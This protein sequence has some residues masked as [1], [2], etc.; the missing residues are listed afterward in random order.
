MAQTSLSVPRVTLTLNFP[1]TEL[2]RE[3]WAHSRTGRLVKPGFWEAR[4]ASSLMGTA[5]YEWRNTPFPDDVWQ[6]PNTGVLMMMPQVL[7]ADLFSNEA[8]LEYAIRRADFLWGDPDQVE[9]VENPATGGYLT[10]LK[11]PTGS[12]LTEILV[13]SALS[14]II[15]L[16]FGWIGRTETLISVNQGWSAIISPAGLTVDRAKAYLGFHWANN[17]YIEFST[18][19]EFTVAYNFGNMDAAEWR[20]IHRA[21]FKTGSVDHKLPFQVTVIPWGRSYISVLFSQVT[22]GATL[23]VPRDPKLG[24]RGAQGNAFLIDLSEHGIPT[25]WADGIAQHIKTPGA[26]LYVAANIDSNQY[27]FWISRVVYPESATFDTGPV[28]MDFAKSVVPTTEY[29]GFADYDNSR[30]GAPKLSLSMID[31]AGDPWTT[32]ETIG[33]IRVSMQSDPEQKYSPELWSYVAKVD[34]VTFTPDWTPVDVSDKWASIRLELTARSQASGLTVKLLGGDLAKYNKRGGP[35]RLEIDR[36]DGSGTVPVFDGYVMRREPTTEGAVVAGMIRGKMREE[37]DAQDMWHRLNSQTMARALPIEN[38]SVSEIIREAIQRTGQLPSEIEIDAEL[39][40]I[41]YS[42]VV[43]ADQSKAWS[44]DTYVGDVVR[45]VEKFVSAQFS[46]GF[47]VR[48]LGDRW[49]CY[50]AYAWDEAELWPKNIFLLDGGLM[51][52]WDEVMGT[53]FDGLGRSDVERWNPS[54]A[55]GDERFYLM[56]SEFEPDINLPAFNCLEVIAPAGDKDGDGALMAVIDPDPEVLLDSESLIFEGRLRKGQKGPPEITDASEDEI[57]RWARWFYD[58]EQR[59]GTVLGMQG[60]WQPEVMPDGFVMI[61]GRGPG[62]D[63]VS[64][65]C[66]RIE[67]INVDIES[68]RQQDWSWSGS[69]DLVYQGPTAHPYFPMVSDLVDSIA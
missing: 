23:G 22:L 4:S 48:W 46:D 35:I 19:G 24:A 62:G 34:P 6:E 14:D 51:A 33:A 44:S 20:E 16:G 47:R 67:S 27:V 26:P 9:E 53:A 2:L 12:S 13:A 54:G 43:T 10:V 29:R 21:S 56:T 18:A 5:A 1:R 15:K 3:G 45:D 32:D 31:R 66:W 60:E 52:Y 68:D 30:P 28:A 36:A 69:Y 41:A 42:D 49:S 38:R 61:L 7:R 39:D 59:R 37:L 57:P 55:F 11:R 58:R 65:G 50:F 63:P 8:W 25:P 17:F 64:F 40:E